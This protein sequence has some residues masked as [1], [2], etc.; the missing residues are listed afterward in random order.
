MAVAG[1]K[2]E[3]IPSLYLILIT[4]STQLSDIDT[5]HEFTQLK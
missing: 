4:P 3:I 5:T 1:L 2:T